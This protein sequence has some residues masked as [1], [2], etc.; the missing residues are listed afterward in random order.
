MRYGAYLPYFKELRKTLPG[1][2]F[3]GLTGADRFVPSYLYY[4]L[5]DYVQAG[6]DTDAVQKEL[7]RKGIDINE[8]ED[9][10]RN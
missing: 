5:E 10:L 3:S 9:Y 8:L 2:R 6:G 1:S 7:I 4:L